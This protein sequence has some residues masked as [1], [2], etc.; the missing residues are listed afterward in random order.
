FQIDFDLISHRL[1]L[2]TSLGEIRTFDLQG[3]TVADFYNRIFE[4][5]KEL[6][7]DIKIWPVPSE[8]ENPI[9]FPQDQL[10]ATYDTTQVKA[11]HQALLSIHDVF[12]GFRCGF[13]GKCSPV[14]F[15]WGGFDLAVTRFSE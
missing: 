12:N 10:H 15:F 7:I 4:A 13:R 5:L 2:S 11:Y 8:L 1:K 3:V 14:H 9:P 6:D